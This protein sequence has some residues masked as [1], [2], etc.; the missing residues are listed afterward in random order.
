MLIDFE[1]I[2]Q[3]YLRGALQDGIWRFEPVNPSNPRAGKHLSTY[4]VFSNAGLGVAL[5]LRNDFE[6]EVATRV[7]VGLKLIFSRKVKESYLL[8]RDDQRIS[9]TLDMGGVRALYAWLQGDTSS[10]SYEIVRP[11]AAKKQISGF[12]TDLAFPLNIR[13]TESDA[14][15]SGRSISVGLADADIFHLE[16]HCLAFAKVLYPSLSD[17]ALLAHLKPRMPARARISPSIGAP[18]K[19]SPLHQPQGASTPVTQ[20]DPAGG[21]SS[22]PFDPE[23]VKKAVFAVGKSKWS[24]KDLATIEHIQSG[25]VEAMDRFVKE[26]NAGNFDAWDRLYS[27]LHPENS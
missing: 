6:G 9:L 21:I 20:Q 8:Q 5:Y 7:H 14:Y 17:T 12:E 1:S 4:Q 25:P 16:V 22:A 27:L 10:F 15:G 2:Y 11:D 18:S 24:R 23:R 13:V 3:K 19:D 26:G